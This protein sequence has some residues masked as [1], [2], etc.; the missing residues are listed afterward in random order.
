MATP[1]QYNT[2]DKWIFFLRIKDSSKSVGNS[3]A[4]DFLSSEKDDQ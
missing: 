3:K 1:T 2:V 4:N